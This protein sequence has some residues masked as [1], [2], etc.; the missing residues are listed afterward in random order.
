MKSCRSREPRRRSYMRHMSHTYKTLSTK[1]LE[2][3][4]KLLSTNRTRINKRISPCTCKR[5]M[6]HRFWRTLCDEDGNE[7]N[8]LD[9][10]FVGQQ[11]VR[12]RKKLTEVVIFSSVISDEK[13][14][15]KNNSDFELLN[16]PMQSERWNMW[17][18]KFSRNLTVSV[19]K[20]SDFR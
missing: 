3:L 17:I 18:S 4:E 16:Y 7:I 20:T 19:W 10:S 15:F 9:D 14:K 11:Q 6:S 1:R 13:H 8:T 2:K 5:Q 12:C